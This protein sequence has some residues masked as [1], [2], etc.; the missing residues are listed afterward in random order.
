MQKI[1]WLSLKELVVVLVI[2][3][4]QIVLLKEAG[5]IL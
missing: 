2:G 5:D 4:E 3:D 1:R